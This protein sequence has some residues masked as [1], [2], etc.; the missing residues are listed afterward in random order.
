MPNWSWSGEIIKNSH[1]I[2]IR[3]LS[4]QMVFKCGEQNWSPDRILLFL[5]EY[6]EMRCHDL[7]NGV[8]LSNYLVVLGVAV[9]QHLYPPHIYV[10]SIHLVFDSTKMCV[11]KGCWGTAWHRVKTAK[12]I[13]A[14]GE[15][16]AGYENKIMAFHRLVGTIKAAWLFLRSI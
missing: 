8:R 1:Y 6:I 3:Y 5:M 16:E 10:E 4:N 13:F 15:T 7:N 11:D 12:N 2:Y 9:P 14:L